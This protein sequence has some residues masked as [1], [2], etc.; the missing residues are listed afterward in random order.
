MVGGCVP[1]AK[2]NYRAQN[3]CSVR[4]EMLKFVRGCVGLVALCFVLPG[5][6]VG[7]SEQSRNFEAVKR[8]AEQGDAK[9]QTEL[10]SMYAQAQGVALNDA[11]AVKW[12]QKA[13]E[14]GD[15]EAQFFLGVRYSGGYGIAQND[16]EAVKW[17]RLAAEQGNAK[18]QTELGEMYLRGKNGI[19]EDNTEAE[20]WTRLAAEQG[21]MYA[22]VSLG[23]TYRDPE[24]VKWYRL[25]AEQGYGHAQALLGLVYEGG[26]EA[27]F[28][29]ARDYAEA[30]K[31]YQKAIEQGDDRVKHDLERVL[32]KMA[33][34]T[35]DQ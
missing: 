5:T 6:L 18:A 2:S 20:K 23:Q 11:E 19:T 34:D 8:M 16:A 33:V 14:Q 15:A 7:C 31:W 4:D 24:A 29:V 32:A 1:L 21:N 26:H 25:A 10:G 13:A 9:A 27:G 35:E 28:S 30:A 3:N 22:Q 17:I 12:F